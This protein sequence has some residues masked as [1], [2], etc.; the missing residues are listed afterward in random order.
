MGDDSVGLGLRFGAGVSRGVVTAA[1]T[2]AIANAID[3]FTNTTTIVEHEEGGENN[4]EEEFWD[5]EEEL[6]VI[7]IELERLVGYKP[8]TVEEIESIKK[9]LIEAMW[10]R[11]KS[12]SNSNGCQSDEETKEQM[13]KKQDADADDQPSEEEPPPDFDDQIKELLDSRVARFGAVDSGNLEVVLEDSNQT[14]IAPPSPFLE[15][16]YPSRIL[17]P[18]N[19]SPD[20]QT[21]ST[22][23]ETTARLWSDIR[24][25]SYALDEEIENN[26]NEY[27]QDQNDE[28]NEDDIKPPPKNTHNNNDASFLYHLS[29]HLEHTGRLLSWK[30]SMSLELKDMLFRESLHK[31]HELWVKE[32]RTAKLGQLYQVRETL[33]HRTEGAKFDFD[34]LVVAKDNAIRRDMLQYD[35]N[36]KR[37]KRGE[38]S[39]LLGGG[40]LSFPEE[41]E[42]MGLLPKDSQ[43]YEEEDWGGTLDDDDDFDYYNS[44]YS[45][46]YSDDDDD[47][48]YGSDSDR[49][50]FSGDKEGGDDHEQRYPLPP[51][52]PKS[53]DSPSNPIATANTESISSGDDNKNNNNNT[54]LDGIGKE[55]PTTV[56]PKPFWNR[57]RQRRKKKAR[58]RKKKELAE[59]QRREETSKRNHHEAFL[60]DKHTTN[61]LVLAQTLLEA[62]EKKVKDVEELLENLQE[63]EWAAEEEAEQE[64][65]Q[66]QNVHNNTTTDNSAT[67][68]SLLDQILAMILGALPMEAGSKDRERH[69]RY[70]KEEHEFIVSGWKDYFGRLPKVFVPGEQEDP[71]QAADDDEQEDALPLGNPATTALSRKIHKPNAGFAAPPSEALMKLSKITSK[72]SA[73]ANTPANANAV[74]AT[75][76]EQRMALG[77]VDNEDADWDIL[78]DDNDE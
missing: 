63:E 60:K 20:N 57:N 54:A 18:N 72:K 78:A 44:D 70:V 55:T 76:Q 77:I 47:D 28:A 24:S 23:L 9:Q 75:P 38:A 67:G 39:S 37:K 53:D 29:D 22:T 12:S 19:A 16:M 34:K 49:S 15:I 4:I 48:G 42:L 65:E 8:S 36:L 52:A 61:E 64:D 6:P 40:E 7:S 3:A 58:A 11:Y 32:Q 31:K 1:D 33:V 51:I 17:P 43:L 30:H 13:D 66:A 56:V 26:Y 73:A 46:D 25:L 45:D 21:N 5:E 50:G 74:V 10:M 59:T 71:H 41:F 62:L 69:F 2:N 35:Y 14:P 68:M 27:E